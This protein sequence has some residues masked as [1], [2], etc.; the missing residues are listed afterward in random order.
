MNIKSKTELDA[1]ILV[2]ENRKLQQERLLIEQFKVTRESLSPLNL[3]KDGFNKLTNLPNLQDGLLK[4]V[5]GIGV[6]VLSKKLFLGGS[7]S[8][9]KKLLSGVVEFVVAKST[10]SNADKI[11]AYGQSIYHNLFKKDSNHKEPNSSL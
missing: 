5:T 2:L 9:I 6:G 8:I 7:T 3:I 11:K 10:I 1:A 4:T